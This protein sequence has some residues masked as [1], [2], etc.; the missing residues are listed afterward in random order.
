[1]Q[2]FLLDAE[3]KKLMRALVREVGDDIPLSKVLNESTDWKGRREQIA[4][5]KNTI[6][7]G[8]IGM[9]ASISLELLM[10][11]LLFLVCL[12]EE[13]DMRLLLGHEW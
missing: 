8:M 1:M 4:H 12:E 13:Q 3:N 10:L 2:V 7:H 6:R 9:H 11:M 5:L